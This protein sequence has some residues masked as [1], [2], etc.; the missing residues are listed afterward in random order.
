MLYEMLAGQPPF[1]GP[2]A[3]AIM[4]RHAMDSVPGLRLVRDTVPEEVEDAILCALAKVPADRPQT[5]AQFAE[6]LGLPLGSTAT[7]RVGSRSGA[8]RRISTATG[9]RVS[10]ATG[11]RLSPAESRRISTQ[12]TVQLEGVAARRRPW[13]W[14]LLAIPVVALA[15]F[16]VWRQRGHAG[17]VATAGGLDP[18][19]VAVLYFDDQSTKHDLG[20]LADGLTEALI[21]A[22]SEVPSLHVVSK[23]GVAQF[24]GGSVPR[25]SIARALQAGTL[26]QGA[27]EQEGSGLRATVRLI[28]GGSGAEFQRASSEQRGG[29]VLALRDSLA[30]DV[31]RLIRARLGE[32]IRIREQ[33]EG[34]SSPD[35]WAQ[36]QRADQARKRADSLAAAGDTAGLN[37]EFRAADSLAELAEHLDQKWID[38]VIMRG[39]VAYRRSRL[40]GDDPPQAGKWIDVGMGHVQR[41]LALDANNPDAL[42]LRGNLQ[43]WRW[44]LN[45]EPDAAK[46]KALLKAAQQDLETAVRIRPAQAG[47]WATLSHLYYQTGSIADVSLAAR[48]ALEEDAYLSNADVVQARLF[49]A[50]Y[51][52]GQFVDATHW[53][54][55]GQRRFPADRKFVE[56][57]LLLLATKGTDPNV[58]KAWRL[59]DSLFKL[60]PEPDRPFQ[61][62]NGQMV[63]AAVL[64]RAGLADS[65]RHVAE[66]S[67]GDAQID[68]TRDL[69]E[70]GAFVY[71][72]L[73]D[74]DE[75]LKLLK[76]YLAANPQRR[77]NYAEDPGVAVPEPGGGSPVRPDGRRQALAS[78][79]QTA[80]FPKPQTTVIAPTRFGEYFCPRSQQ[81]LTRA[82]PIQTIGR[83]TFA[84]SS[85]LR[86]SH[87]P[88]PVRHRPRSARPR[89]LYRP[90]PVPHRTQRPRC[91]QPGDSARRLPDGGSNRQDDR[92]AVP[93][94]GP[95]PDRSGQVRG[96]PAQA[97]LA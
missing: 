45:L 64:A 40:S 94:A 23:G 6:M 75:A 97:G 85:T 73:G 12:E 47:A 27:V 16:L 58:G 70:S 32:E 66:R 7:R 49:Y 53:C 9:R 26:V 28:D 43:Y 15:G 77:S 57:Q 22:L 68:P 5:A 60:T 48:R 4:A 37:R 1:T 41:A 76:V 79:P 33:R 19:R 86:S 65:A 89:R 87:A 44:L 63:V 82:R 29:D 72:L 56:C 2:N 21:G 90:I 96:D 18:R 24:R 71:T 84:S 69:V 62:L 35:A 13:L 51:D 8:S 11:G 52:Q 17:A 59:A 42:E 91:H 93:Q 74:Q 92:Q 20:Y 46:A 67:K 81:A 50:S 25:D 10:T 36:L 83:L 88:S 95:G 3:R 39:T 14:G 30:R 54:Q 80:S 31:A 38:P 61:R 34:A 55:E 78:G